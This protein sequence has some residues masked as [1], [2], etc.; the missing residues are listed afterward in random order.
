MTSNPKSQD[1][2][3]L[4]ARA[5]RP[6][7][8]AGV[9]PGVSFGIFLSA[10][11]IANDLYE[12]AGLALQPPIIHG[13]AVTYLLSLAVNLAVGI[14]AGLAVVGMIRLWRNLRLLL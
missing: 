8:R 1:R 13:S 2:Q 6:S 11:E 14:M 5:R 4:E 9:L 10:G 3:F 7:W 12:R